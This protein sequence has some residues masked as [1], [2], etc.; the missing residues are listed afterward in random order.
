MNLIYQPTELCQLAYTYGTDKCPQVEHTY[1][2]F[3]FELLKD[4]RQTIKK[5]LE[6]GVGHHEDMKHVVKLKGSYLLGASLYMWRDFFPNAQIYG[7]DIRPESMF[8]AER[9]KTYVCDQSKKEDL[10]RLIEHIGSDI[11]LVIDDGSHRRE[12]QISTCLTLMPLLKKDV[13][14]VIEDVI[15]SRRVIK[16]LHQYECWVPPISRQR[17]NN[18]LGVVKNMP[19]EVIIFEHEKPTHLHRT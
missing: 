18:Q 11:D 15:H 17:R 2:P 1:T 14:Y 8:E 10:V 19:K 7:A 5:V 6:I 3:Y 9:I 13:I 16:A 12:H 4:K